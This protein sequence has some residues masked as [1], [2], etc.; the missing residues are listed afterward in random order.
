MVLVMTF[1]SLTV[2][3]GKAT[4]GDKPKGFRTGLYITKDGRLRLNIEK[5]IRSSTW[6]IVRNSKGDVLIKEMVGRNA[7]KYAMRF[8][9]SN[10]DAGNYTLEILSRGEKEVRPFSIAVPEVKP[11]RLL[12]IL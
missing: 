11:T 12:S 10:L 5:E 7:M 4:D 2:Y 3:S 1:V 9:V 8:D 6:F